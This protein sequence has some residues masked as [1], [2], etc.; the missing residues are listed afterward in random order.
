MELNS[1]T[2][3]LFG[4]V[5]LMNFSIAIIVLKSKSAILIQPKSTIPM[6]YSL[7][8]LLKVNSF[9]KKITGTII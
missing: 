7:Q 2:H 1:P 3:P 6:V 4:I 5:P 9:I 8:L